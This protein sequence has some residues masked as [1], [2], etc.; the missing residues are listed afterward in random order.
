M[1]GQHKELSDLEF[2]F[3]GYEIQDAERMMDGT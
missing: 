3:Q 2:F 1:C